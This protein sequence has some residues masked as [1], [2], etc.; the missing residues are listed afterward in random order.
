MTEQDMAKMT[1]DEALE[2]L[3]G[4]HSRCDCA[5]QRVVRVA[6]A[7]DRVRGLRRRDSNPQPSQNSKRHDTGR[8]GCVCD[9]A[10]D[11][12]GR[13]ERGSGGDPGT[14]CAERG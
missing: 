8:D 5:G 10:L 13:G 12:A 6:G 14:G 1:P 11:R 9:L 2:I 3:R 7:A 4:L